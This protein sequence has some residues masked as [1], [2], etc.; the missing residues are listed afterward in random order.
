MKKSDQSPSIFTD[1]EKPKFCFDDFRYDNEIDYDDSCPSCNRSL[2]EHTQNERIQC[3]LD[4][5]GRIPH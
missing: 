1:S 2:S 3:A 4:R 5:I